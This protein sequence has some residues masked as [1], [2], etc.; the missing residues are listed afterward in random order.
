M[1]STVRLARAPLL[2]SDLEARHEGTLGE[3]SGV[4]RHQ[5]AWE[6]WSWSRTRGRRDKASRRAEAVFCGAH[7]NCTGAR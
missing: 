6:R 5:G 3:K 2:S 7:A 1:P 4:D